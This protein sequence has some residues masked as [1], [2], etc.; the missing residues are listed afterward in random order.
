MSNGEERP[1]D[2]TSRSL[3]QAEQNYAQIEPEA[4]A[5][6]FAVRK[7]HQ[8]LCRREFTLVTDHRLQDIGGE[9]RHPTYSSSQ[10]AEVGVVA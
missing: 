6:V 1:V 9:R 2:Y 5:I 10:D 7:F 8:Y 3:S 4:L